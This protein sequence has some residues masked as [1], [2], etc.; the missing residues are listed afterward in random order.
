MASAP[1]AST[2][3]GRTVHDVALVRADPAQ[4]PLIAQL[5]QLYLHDVSQHL[6]RESPWGEVDESGL[7]AYPPGLDGYWGEP[8]RIPYLIRADGRV[9]GFVLLNARSALDL[10]VD[11]AVA[12]FFVLRKNRRAGI[13]TRAAHLAIRRHPGRWEAAVS[14]FN[15]EALPF[16][17]R[18]V[19]TLSPS[20]LEERA[21]DEGDTVLRFTVP[22]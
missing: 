13:G 12:E 11:H 18:T 9:A 4:R 8:D 22:G 21:G 20:C 14:R 3:A 10:P 6:P 2:P 15:P 1:D 17:R 7:F 16:W 5:L 19:A